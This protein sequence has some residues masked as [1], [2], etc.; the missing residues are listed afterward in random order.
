MAYFAIKCIGMLTLERLK[1]L[2][3]LKHVRQPKRQA[4][5]APFNNLFRIQQL[6]LWAY[7]RAKRLSKSTSLL[8]AKGSTT[9][10]P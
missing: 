9:P 6:K 8:K 4:S 10:M 3:C 2:Q 7:Y 1:T 5:T